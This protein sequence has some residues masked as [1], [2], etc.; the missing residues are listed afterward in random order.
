VYVSCS[1]TPTTTT[2]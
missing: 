2:V 1:S